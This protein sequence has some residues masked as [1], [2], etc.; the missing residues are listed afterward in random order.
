V[1]G[2]VVVSLLVTITEVGDAQEVTMAVLAA[3]GLHV[4]EVDAQQPIVS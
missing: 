2:V 3:Q 4:A 1:E